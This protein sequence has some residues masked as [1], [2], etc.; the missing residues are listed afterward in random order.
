MV[1]GLQEKAMGKDNSVS[2]LVMKAYAISRKL[3]LVEFEEWLN[4]ELNGYENYKGDEWPA[5]RTVCGE[6]KGWNPARGWIPVILD[7][8]KSYD[9]ICNKKVYNPISNFE[10]MVNN[11]SGKIIMLFDPEIN[12]IISKSTGFNTRYKLLIDRTSIQ[13]ICDAVRGHILEWALVLEEIGVK[14]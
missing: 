10:D 4:Y 11:D 13:S 14:G 6:L 1:I 12:N 2:F 7:D 9:M 3:E 8:K 5:Y